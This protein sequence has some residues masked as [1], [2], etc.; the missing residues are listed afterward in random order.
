MNKHAEHR[1]TARL[2]S[3]RWWLAGLLAVLLFLFY[4]PLPYYVTRP[5]SAIELAPMIQVEGGTKDEK[6]AFMLTTVRMGEASPIWYLYSKISPDV[7]LIDKDLV[8]G[9]GESD[10]D[11]TKRELEVMKGSQQLAEAV[12]FRHAGYPVKIENQGVIVMGTIE[13]LPAKNVLKVG[14]VITAI[15]QQK[16]TTT[17]ELLDFLAKKKPGDTIQV[18]YQREG[19]EQTSPITL[20]PLPDEKGGPSNRVGLGIR[21]DNKQLIEIPK[22]V[23]ISAEG[24]GGP[25]AGLMM[26]LEIYDQL[27]KEMD[28]THGYRIAG[29]GTISADGTVGRIGGINHKIVAA[30]RAGAE[31][32]FAPNDPTTGDEE[33]NYQEAVET[34]KRI[35]TKMTVVPVK[36][37]DDAISYLMNLK[38]K[39]S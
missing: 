1:T 11:F 5:G 27:K 15:D 9:H 23:S 29:T 21:P 22:K 14:D 7:E 10:D 39:H 36:T 16:V 20:A 33:S 37:V 32:F 34:A 25:S 35:G 2:H 38:E 17:Q 3:L 12:A 13:G 19:K 6:G 8:L 26:T 4:L 31:I 18:T 24:I 28:L 30:D